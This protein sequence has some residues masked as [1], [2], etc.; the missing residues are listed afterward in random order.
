MPIF[1]FFFLNYKKIIYLPL[2]LFLEYYQQFIDNIKYI[3]IDF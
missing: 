2:F 1:F 3:Y